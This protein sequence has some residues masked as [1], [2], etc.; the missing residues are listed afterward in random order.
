MQGRNMYGGGGQS[1]GHIAAA[2]R[3]A[4][5]RTRECVWG[6]LRHP[7]SFQELSLLFQRAVAQPKLCAL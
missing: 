5:Q 2:G 3:F 4:G 7:P 6:V 1:T